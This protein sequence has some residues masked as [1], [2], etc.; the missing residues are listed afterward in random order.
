VEDVR[1]LLPD[2][3]FTPWE[4]IG[5]AL[6]RAIARPSAHPIV[7]ASAF[8][9]YAGRPLPR[10]L[11]LK[12]WMSVALLRPP[13]DFVR[14]LGVLPEGVRVRNGR[15]PGADLSIWFVRNPGDLLRRMASL[16]NGLVHGVLWIA[17]LKGGTSAAGQLTQASVRRAGLDAGLVD[18]KICSIDERWSALL[19]K[20]R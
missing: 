15:L 5:T 7:P 1:R 2:A 3:T 19:F 17:W 20:H 12:P 10:K 16:A 11:G 13:P 18:Y 9:A 8:A 4:R 6:K 14:R